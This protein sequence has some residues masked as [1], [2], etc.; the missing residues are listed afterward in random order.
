[1]NSNARTAILLV[2]LFLQSCQLGAQAAAAASW[3]AGVNDES[4]LAEI[5]IPG[6]HDSGARHNPALLPG[7][8]AC[9]TLSIREQLQIGVRFLDIRLKERGGELLVYHGAFFQNLSFDS[10]L[11]DC[12][13]FLTDHP[14]ECIIMSVQ[15]CGRRFEEVFQGCLQAD[16][17]L[18]DLGE[19]IP[20]LGAVRGKMTLLRRF[21]AANFRVGIDAT[22]WPDNR[23][24]C[25]NMPTA[26]LG[27]QDVYIVWSNHRKWQRIEK[28]F[29]DSTAPSSP[30]LFLN[31]TSGYNPFL[32]FW[33]RIRHCT[34]AIHP[35]LERYLS[36][37]PAAP[38]PPPR[39]IV[40][41][42]FVTAALCQDVVHA[43]SKPAVVRR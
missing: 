22:A 12:R 14:S 39:G 34:D 7:T 6:S 29:I 3:M 13:G 43:N 35:R 18:W 32:L 24:F 31:F 11:L 37:I 21:P 42:D 36:Q 10:V 23:V 5:L 25:L 30:P 16:S 17:N 28:L 1:M 15:G 4:S 9:Q 2:L 38:G 8:T 26:S 40:I 41:M 19:S 20:K 33:P 27:V